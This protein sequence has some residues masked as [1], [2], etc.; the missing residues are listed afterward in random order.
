MTT[1]TPK[2]KRT[3]RPEAASAR[4]KTTAKRAKPRKK[5]ATKKAPA[6][7]AEATSLVRAF[8][9]L[10]DKVWN[11]TYIRRTRDILDKRR[12]RADRLR[13]DTK[14]ELV[15]V[16]EDFRCHGWLLDWGLVRS[17]RLEDEVIDSLN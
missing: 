14:K 13:A 2:T 3:T 9:S 17:A 4:R 6:K 11:V 8:E 5:A 16:A 15:A 10:P 7:P 12:R 1:A